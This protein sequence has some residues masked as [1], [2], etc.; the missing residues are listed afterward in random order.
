MLVAHIKP[1]LKWFKSTIISRK[2]TDPS[3]PIKYAFIFYALH[4]KIE[5]TTQTTFAVEFGTYEINKLLLQ[6]TNGADVRW[7]QASKYLRVTKR[8]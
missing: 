4:N 1:Y 8:L 6:V 2:V 7:Q 3:K 5:K